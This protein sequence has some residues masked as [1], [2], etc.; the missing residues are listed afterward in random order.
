MSLIRSPTSSVTVSEQL[1]G[2]AASPIPVVDV[3]DLLLRFTM[4]SAA[5]F[6]FGKDLGTLHRILPVQGKAKLGVKGS[7]TEDKFSGFVD[8]KVSIP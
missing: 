4:D 7:A 6:L 8:G 2:I 1:S 5:E 3:Q